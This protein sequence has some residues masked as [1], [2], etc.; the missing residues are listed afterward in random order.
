[1]ASSPS[2][3]S[4]SLSNVSSQGSGKLA[5]SRR[6]FSASQFTIIDELGSGSFGVVYNAYDT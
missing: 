4:S 1:M 6:E 3:S 2:R 5:Q